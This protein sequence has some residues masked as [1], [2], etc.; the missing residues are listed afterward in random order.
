MKKLLLTTAIAFCFAG[1]AIAQ[2]PGKGAAKKRPVTLTTSS[3]SADN[4]TLMAERLK[5]KQKHF[6]TMQTES[7]KTTTSS[8]KAVEANGSRA[9]KTN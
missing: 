8:P 9:K 5:A 3:P 2:E 1:V 4:P 7:S 6:E